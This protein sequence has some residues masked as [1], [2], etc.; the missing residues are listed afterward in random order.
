MSQTINLAHGDGGELTHQLIQDV[1]VKAF[2]NNEESKFDAAIIPVQQGKIAVT[3]DSFVVKPLFFAGG[4]IG[5][6]AISGTV[7]DLAVSGAKPLYLTC[8]FVIEE[9]FPLKDLKTIVQDMADEAKKAGVALVAGDTKVVE[10]GGCDGVFINTTGIGVL[11]KETETTPSFEVGDDVIISGTLGDHGIAILTS[12]GD[13]GIKSDVK[14]D[15]APLNTMLE[16]ATSVSKQVR[17]MRDPTRGGLTT[18]LV[19]IAE[20]FSV[21]ITLE[22]NAIP[23][24]DEVRGAC[25]LLGYDPL[26][27]ANEGKAIIIVAHDDVNHVL[28]AIR[29]LPEGQD[30]A[31]I[32]KVTDTSKGQLLIETP[33][34]VKRALHRL[35]GVMLPRIC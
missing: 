5:K 24:K 26:Y 16:K 33:L 13:L 7:N 32:G 22:E 28:E 30:A 14:S 35:S 3:T 12:R 8:G 19:E 20:D 23:I 18:T 21:T 1:F 6:L 4:S 29:K 34:G 27:L 31:C 17:I 10:R 15:C 9:G 2:G 11:T 25:D